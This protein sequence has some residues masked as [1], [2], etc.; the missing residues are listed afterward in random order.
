[1][2]AVKCK[3][4]GKQYEN[5]KCK[6]LQHGHIFDGEVKVDGERIASVMP[7]ETS[8]SA[9]ETI[10]DAKGMYVIPGLLDVHF[11]GCVGYD[12]CDASKEAFDK[13]AAYEAVRVFLRS[14][15]RR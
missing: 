15:L 4:K 7:K 5:F 2:Q 9:D 3:K 12:T 14:V 8:S 13:I 6:D 11:H 1:M 10:I